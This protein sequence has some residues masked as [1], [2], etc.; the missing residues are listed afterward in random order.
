[1]A[2]PVNQRSHDG[3]T[4]TGAG[5]EASRKGHQHCTV[6]ILAENLDTAND[7][8]TVETEA[9]P[10]GESP[11]VGPEAWETVDTAS[12]ADF[13]EDPDNPGNYVYSVTFSGSYHEYLRTRVDA[14]TDSAGGDLV[15]TSWVMAAGYPASSGQ[16]KPEHGP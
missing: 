16:G 14:F 1:M 5:N 10:T 8:L 11:D 9:S 2:H 13:T 4:A 7:T 3:A 6:F 15:V 12:A